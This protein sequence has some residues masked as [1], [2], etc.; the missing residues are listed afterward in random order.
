MILFPILW[1]GIQTITSYFSSE[2]LIGN[3]SVD[4]I[5]VN[6]DSQLFCW[7]VTCSK[8]FLRSPGGS[9]SKE[10]SC[11]VGDLGSIPGFGKSPGEGSSYPLQY[12]GLENSMAYTVMGLLR[13]GHNWL[14]FTFNFTCSKPAIPNM[15]NHH[16]G[17]F[18]ENIDFQAQPWEI[19]TFYFYLVAIKAESQPWLQIR[20]LCA[21]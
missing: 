9:A 14:I 21:D 17:M 3:V 10:S 2:N 20:I 5:T 6:K 15:V 11:N 4:F 18:P 12:S 1:S 19:F 16:T 8:G 13:V 7:G